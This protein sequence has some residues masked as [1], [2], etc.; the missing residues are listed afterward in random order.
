MNTEEKFLK[1]MMSMTAVN[2]QMTRPQISLLAALEEELVVG[3]K[4][5][6]ATALPPLQEAQAERDRVSSVCGG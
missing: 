4:V 1:E 5:K 3:Q 2:T 6:P